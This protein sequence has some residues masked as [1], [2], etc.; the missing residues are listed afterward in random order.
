[1]VEIA[2]L[3]MV[4]GVPLLICLVG[5]LGSHFYDGDDASLLDWKLTRSAELE[6][7]IRSSDVEQMLDAVNRYRQA[8]GAGERS[9]QELTQP[10]PE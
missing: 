9:L 7:Q 10:P 3:S 5:V 1:M 2:F 8:R 6:A 4:L